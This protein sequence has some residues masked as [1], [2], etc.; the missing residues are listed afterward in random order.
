MILFMN[1]T[2]Q[3]ALSVCFSVKLARKRELNRNI[4]HYI[5]TTNSHSQLRLNVCLSLVIEITAIQTIGEKV[6]TGPVSSDK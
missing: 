6:I 4:Y 5:Q 2:T 1:Q 3:L